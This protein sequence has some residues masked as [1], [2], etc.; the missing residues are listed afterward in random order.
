MVEPVRLK[1]IT[2]VRKRFYSSAL[3]ETP[4]KNTFMAVRTSNS[5]PCLS[6]A[7]LETAVGTANVTSPPVMPL[8][9]LAALSLLPFVLLSK[10]CG[11]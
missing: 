2:V 4:R 7:C 8:V 11:Q 9:A 10:N 3:K 5:N 6:S 1:H